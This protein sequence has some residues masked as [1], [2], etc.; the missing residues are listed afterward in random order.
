M[1]CVGA[2]L[3]GVIALVCATARIVSG[4]AA[5]DVEPVADGVMRPRNF[6]RFFGA[7]RAAMDCAGACAP[8]NAGAAANAAAAAAA[9][10]VVQRIDAFISC[11]YPKTCGQPG[12]PSAFTEVPAG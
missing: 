6:T 3:N 10:K 11:S 5:A 2:A 12:C 8:A 7:G 9:I 1:G 4:H